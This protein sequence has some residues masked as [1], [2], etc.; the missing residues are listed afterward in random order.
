MDC[1]FIGPRTTLNWWQRMLA[2]C[3]SR[4]C[5]GMVTKEV[6]RVQLL[7][8]P[9]PR[10]QKAKARQPN[11]HPVTVSEYGKSWIR[12]ISN[13]LWHDPTKTWLSKRYR[14]R[15]PPKR[16]RLQSSGRNLQ[17][18]LDQIRSKMVQNQI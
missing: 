18:L 17:A 11:H 3:R 7:K 6:Q 13:P 8:Q 1:K 2:A 14:V 16:A 15:K 12:D 5:L 4:L 10:T 9:R